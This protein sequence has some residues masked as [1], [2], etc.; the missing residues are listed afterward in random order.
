MSNPKRFRSLI[1]D[2]RTPFEEAFEKTIAHLTSNEDYFSWITNP[3]KT[4]SQ[5]LDIMAKEAGVNDWF[6]SDLESDKRDSIEKAPTIHRKSGT[7][8][9]LLDGLEALGC[10][11]QISK[12]AMPYS[13]RIF[14]II[15]N[16]PLTVDLQARLKERVKH[17]KAERDTV[18]LELGRFWLGEHYFVNKLSKGKELRFK[19]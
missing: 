18:E 13:L 19:D 12:G 2:N 9:G 10:K 15:V 8:Q 6:A 4:H 11:A 1:P 14:N 7:R 16:K 17:T 5:L 3:Q